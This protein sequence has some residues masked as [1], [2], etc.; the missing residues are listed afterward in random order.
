MKYSL[1]ELTHD[2]LSAIMEAL[3]AGEQI[4]GARIVQADRLVIE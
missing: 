3:K 4:D 1:Y 2:Y